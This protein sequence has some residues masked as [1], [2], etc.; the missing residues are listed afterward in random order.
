[1]DK[2]PLIIY[3][4]TFDPVHLGHLTLVE[5]LLSIHPT[6]E[7]H[8][9]PNQQPVNKDCTMASAEERVAMLELA[10][11]S[12]SRVNID[13]R[14]LARK[15]PSYS[16]LSLR[17]LR[18]EAGDEQPIWMV[19]GDDAFDG[20]LSW[21]QFDNILDECHLLIARRHKQID[22]HW[23]DELRQFYEAH[24]LSSELPLEEQAELKMEPAGRIV[25]LDN[26]L[27]EVSSTAVRR[28]LSQSTSVE[29]YLPS[30]VSSYIKENNLYS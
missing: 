22:L 7:V 18:S 14:E 28:A 3:G 27:V 15:E 8:L 25:A 24:Q 5:Y 2:T 17:E 16:L 26:P 6:A 1:M 13:T 19:I 4:G 10:T 9:M 11:Q 20:F 29:Q 23:T 12:F 30:V 21:Y